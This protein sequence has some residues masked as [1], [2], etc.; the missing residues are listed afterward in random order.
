M[1]QEFIDG[2]ELF[3]YCG[4]KDHLHEVEAQFFFEQIVRGVSWLH[5]W[6]I[7]HR[8]LKM[9]NILLDKTCTQVK[10]ID[11]GLG[12]FYLGKAHLSTF[13][14][15]ADY[16]APELFM[17]KLYDGPS[18]DVWSIG[19]ILYAMLTGFVPFASAQ[20][21]VDV[22]YGWPANIS[23]GANA[24]DLIKRIFQRRVSDRI[25]MEQLRVHPFVKLPVQEEWVADET[26][27]ESI[28][29]MLIK[30]IGIDRE[31]C[32]RTLSEGFNSIS[33]HY[34]MLKAKKAKKIVL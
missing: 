26:I 18:V 12:T 30:E 32:L 7:V 23:V 29:E 19:V 14:G 6:G 5:K 2:C 3:D 4:R 17:R 27:D 16:A 13:C 10:I 20:N 28:V 24:K 11:L 8:D 25:T 33:A 22:K 9:E 21:V 31:L 1:I 15:S 34:K